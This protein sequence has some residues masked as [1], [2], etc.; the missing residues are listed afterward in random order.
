MASTIDITKPVFGNPTTQSVRDN[1]AAAKSE[2][3][4]LQTEKAELDSPA[5]TGSATAVN[6]TASG[7]LNAA[8]TFQV[9]GVAVTSTAAELNILDG[10]TATT[11]ELNFV[12]GVTS[13]I[14]TQLNTKAASADLGT[15][16]TEDVTTSAT[17]TTAGRLLKVG[18]GG[19]QLASDIS[20]AGAQT[21]GATDANAVI[22]K[23]NDLERFLVTSAGDVGIGSSSP[24]RKL[25]V[26]GNAHFGTI[27]NRG[28]FVTL[29]NASNGR[30]ENK[31]NF[32]S[33]D[34]VGEFG[35][36]GGGGTEFLTI[37][38]AGKLLSPNGA[39]FV[40]TVSNSGSGAIIERGANA[41]GRFIK[42]ADRTMICDNINNAITTNPAAFVGPV[43]SVDNNK[44][45]FGYWY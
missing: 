5:F 26:A 11:A 22:I 34:A 20:R 15:A 2:I 33:G 21:L 32:T 14:Q 36:I 4:A 41:N 17:D 25:D 29:A 40:G 18:A 1:F 10:V 42:F 13:N 37:N 24:V 45:R 23:T 7:T 12:D 19:N 6:L 30:S 3:E 28:L 31:V 38:L 27:G 35:F 39:A 8:G 16:A 9:D 43:T 44:L